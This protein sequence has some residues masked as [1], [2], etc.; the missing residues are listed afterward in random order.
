MCFN[1]TTTTLI[2]CLLF[3]SALL[4]IN[5][6][7]AFE[8]EEEQRFTVDNP[9]QVLRILS[10]T[11]LNYF[12]PLITTY[13]QTHETT[14]VLYTVA[15]STEVFKAIHDEKLDYDLVISSAMDLQTKLVNDG[16]AK[17]YSSVETNNLPAWAKWQ[18]SLFAFTQ[19]PAVLIASK[20]GLAE[21][22]VP[23]NRQDLITLLRDNPQY[24][25]GK[26]GT[27]DLRISGAGYLFA[28]QDVRQSDA[29]WRLAEVMGSLSPKLYCCSSDMI[30]DLE[31][32]EILMAY[33]VM[34]S[35]AEAV[36]KSNTDD[37]VI[38][39]SDYTHFLLRTAF[40]PNTST[41]PEAAATFI[42]FLIG[43]GGRKS[44]KQEAGLPP[45]DGEALAKD[46]HLRPIRLGPELLVYLDRIKRKRFLDEWTDAMVQPP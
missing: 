6:A 15:S 5:P 21:L 20:K 43:N 25:K 45:I 41:Q 19:E 42:D 4:P 46:L 14:E 8:K 36:L 37:T 16:F 32:G 27:Y 30:E 1:T 11:D 29:F 34:G 40:I 3:A 24:F 23:N 26:I 38:A 7:V 10:S 35:Y 12:V 31:S 39:L 9:E 17:R 13:Q 33:N 28:T 18:N 44:I 2:R 22:P